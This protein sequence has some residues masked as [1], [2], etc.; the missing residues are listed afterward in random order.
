MI[1]V[2]ALTVGLNAFD[3]AVTYATAGQFLGIL[4]TAMQMIV[5]QSG[6]NGVLNSY[7]GSD[8]TIVQNL[9]NQ[10]VTFSNDINNTAAHSPGD[11]YD[12]WP[13]LKQYWIN[14]AI[15]SNAL[16]EAGN[17]SLD[18]YLSIPGDVAASIA[19]LPSTIGSAVS[20]AA[21]AVTSTLPW[22]ALVIAGVVVFVLFVKK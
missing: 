2:G 1:D 14:V 21:G 16:Q 22:V 9:Q 6:L 8:T 20:A 17:A 7:A 10:Y 12:N 15:E 18:N 4:G 11:S 3:N 19:A 5:G 13:A